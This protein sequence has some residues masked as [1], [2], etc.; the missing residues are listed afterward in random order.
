MVDQ[1]HF[2]MTPKGDIPRSTFSTTHTYKTTFDAGYLVPVLA[3]EVLPGDVY[4]GNVTIFARLA[5][6]LFPIMDSLFLETFFFFVPNRLLWDNWKKMMGEQKNPGDSIAFTT[7]QIVSPANG[8]PVGSIYD[9]FGLPTVGQVTAAGTVTV[10]A[11]PLRAYNFIWGE[12]FRD[13]NLQNIPNSAY[14]TGDT[15][16]QSNYTLLRRGK[17]HDYF[18]SCLPWPSKQTDLGILAGQTAQVKGIAVRDFPT[19]TPLAANANWIETGGTRPT[20]SSWSGQ[21]QQS[22]NT[23]L[24]AIRALSTSAG[25][26]INVYADLGTA[27]GMTINA[28]RLAYST[29]LLVEKDA[30]SGT[31]YTE[32]LRAHF[33]VTPEDSRLQRPEYIGGGHTTIQTS[34]IPQTSATGLTGGSSP[35]GAL[36]AAATAADNHDFQYHATEHGW[37]IGLANVNAELTY[38][39]GLH[40]K[41]TRL[42]RYDHY[43]PAFAHLGEQAVLTQEIYALGTAGGAN[44]ATVFGYQERWAEYKYR[45]SQI[46][47]L[48][49]STSASTIDTWH[50]SQK[51]TSAPGLNN[52]FI[53]DTPP[54]SRVLAAGA[55]ANGQQILFDSVWNISTT[56]AIPMYSIPGWG[57]R[58]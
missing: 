53:Q 11:L 14:S 37:I 16:A 39:Q 20:T 17:K 41:W 24:I 45:P 9:Y 40:R 36:G 18:T 30:R 22:M 6:P 57:T 51:F 46:T 29:Q 13:E 58:L 8:F 4:R 15:D 43:W 28:L 12:W 27:T 32:L 55:A 5:T 38:Q 52:T 19:S 44:D 35:L 33:G 42:T 2:A 50:L 49:R 54:M 31:R 48:F 3:E 56:R 10:N 1:G 21:Y 47:G 25:A 26:G 23:D 34:A 7:P